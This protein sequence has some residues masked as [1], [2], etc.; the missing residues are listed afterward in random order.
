MFQYT[1]TFYFIFPV[2]KYVFSSE[3]YDLSDTE[4]YN[5]SYSRLH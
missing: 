3:K 2:I 1:N 4:K 5:S